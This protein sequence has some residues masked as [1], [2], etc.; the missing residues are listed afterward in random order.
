MRFRQIVSLLTTVCAAGVAAAQNP[1]AI[2]HHLRY[3]VR[4]A[5]QPDIGLDILDRMKSYHVPGVSIAVIDNYRVVFAKG[6]GVAEFGGH[7]PVDTTTLFLAGSISKPVFTSG[8]LRL[9]E[10]RKIP[11]DADVN[12][13][14]KSWHLPESRFTEHEKVTLRRLLTHSA[15]LTVWGFPGYALGTPVPTVP[16]LLDGAPPANTPAVRNDTTPGARWLYSG[17]GMTIAQLVSTDVSGDAFPA[18]MRK[19]VLQPAG[20]SRSTY[21]NPLPT[22]RRGEAASGHEQ[23]DTPIPGGFHVYPEMAAAGLWTTASDLAR[24]AIALSR[25]YRGENGGV[26]STTMAKQMVSKQVHQRPPF[27][28]GYWGLGI[29]VAGEA[30]SLTFSHGGRDE[31]FVADMFMR[32]NTGRGF[33]IMMNGVAGGLMAEIE[34]A[35]AEEYGFGAP[36]RV[37]RAVVA[38]SPAKLGEYVG[39]Y[40]GVAG[41]DTTRLEIS[42]TADGTMLA[43]YNQASKRSAPLAPLGDDKFVGLEGNGAWEFE[44]AERSGAV[45]SLA[46]GNGPNRRVLQRQPSPPA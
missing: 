19:L 5:D 31:G 1:S 15:G 27:G 46:T 3:G 11:L 34:R 25:S 4:I 10:Q 2:D 33:V 24:W 6:Y 22:N 28:N 36:P 23:L 37:T 32:P 42:V 44:R 30:D 18:L 14:L 12:T 21:E 40:V 8:F 7:K 43:F 17:G 39:H 26:L 38:A 13:L 9:V 16:Q 20:M 45:K 41:N 29:S 35:F